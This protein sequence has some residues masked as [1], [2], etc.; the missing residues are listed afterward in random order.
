MKVVILAGGLGTRLGNE[1]R[2]RPKPMVKIGKDP[3]ILHIITIYEYFGIKEFII[4]GGYKYKFIKEF[5]KNKKFKKLDIKIINTGNNS[6]TGGRIYRLKKYIK[7]KQ[8]MVTYG[9]GLAN[10]NII[11]LLKFHNKYKRMATI[12]VVRPPARWGHVTIRKNYISKFDEKNL[13][14]R[15]SEYSI[16]EGLILSIFS[17]SISIY[18]V[19]HRIILSIFYFV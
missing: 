8:F 3:I 11:K 16:Y 18:N 5:F 19:T 2:V 9:D 1:T 12:S 7:E 15:G 10:I 13:F 6:M 14:C 17:I 4:A